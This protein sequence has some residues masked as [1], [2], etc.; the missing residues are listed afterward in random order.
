MKQ[1]IYDFWTQMGRRYLPAASVLYAAI[2]KIWG[3]PFGVEIPAT[4]T[5]VAVFINEVLKRDSDKFFETHDII[6]TTYE[7]EE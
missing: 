2:A 4:L 3:L 7:G 5:A 6:D 1:N